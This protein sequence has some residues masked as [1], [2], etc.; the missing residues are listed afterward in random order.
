[1]KR[2]IFILLTFS[3]LSSTSALALD[4]LVADNYRTDLT[5]VPRL[6]SLGH[7]VTVSDPAT[8]GSE[9]DYG[10]YDVVALQFD[11]AN[12]ADIN[13]LVAAVDAG[14][15]GFV[16]FRMYECGATVAALGLTSS[17][18]EAWQE[19]A[20]FEI[21][22]ATHPITANLS[23]G[24]FDLGFYYMANY[25]SPGSNATVLGTGGD[26]AALV[27]HNTRRAVAAPFYGHPTF[28]DNE[29]Q[30]SLDLTEACLQWAAGQQTVDTE[31]VTFGGLKSLYR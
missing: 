30:A 19:A 3:V 14:H 15:T 16:V 1:M 26:G 31:S 6:E 8:W 22:D 4:I 20:S 11:A 23:A 17:A 24:P 29:T 18:D 2:V 13:H 10:P 5:V 28:H 12:P 9:F 27:V 21:V 25:M 7:A